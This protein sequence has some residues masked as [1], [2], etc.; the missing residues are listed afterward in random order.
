MKLSDY[1]RDNVFHQRVYLDL[2]GHDLYPS[3]KSDRSSHSCGYIQFENNHPTA[4]HLDCNIPL[5]KLQI[6]VKSLYRYSDVFAELNVSYS[7]SAYVSISDIVPEGFI[8]TRV[9]PK[10]DFSSIKVAY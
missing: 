3:R 1:C 4:V 6:V 2:H 5:E 7:A 10:I 9:L 8:A